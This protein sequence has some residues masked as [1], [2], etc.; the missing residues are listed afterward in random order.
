MCRW[1][2]GACS[3]AA[4]GT[5]AR[6]GERVR[7]A[8]GLQ[9]L[10]AAT[11]AVG[12]GPRD[13]PPPPFATQFKEIYNRVLPCVRVRYSS[14][15]DPEQLQASSARGL[16]PCE[17]GLR[18]VAFCATALA[19]PALLPASHRRR[20]RLPLSYLGSRCT[21]RIPCGPFFLFFQCT[22]CVHCSHH[23]S[24]SFCLSFRDTRC[25]SLS[26]C[27][28]CITKSETAASNSERPLA[29]P[30]ADKVEGSTEPEKSQR[31]D[32]PQQQSRSVMAGHQRYIRYIVF[33][34]VVL[35]PSAAHTLRR[36]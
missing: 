2:Y 22:S 16:C 12:A 9:L 34:L 21:Q 11:Q 25:T 17:P 13:L 27:R 20:G 26:I 14:D 36:I 4:S 28:R 30:Q 29:R 7:E 8:G 15:L 32:A 6:V 23:P 35:S 24:R 18:C 31:S 33:A 10:S 1:L 3:D 5:V 19:A